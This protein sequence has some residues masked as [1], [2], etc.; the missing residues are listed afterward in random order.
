MA[1][2]KDELSDERQQLEKIEARRTELVNAV[3]VKRA[4]LLTS[5]QAVEHAHSPAGIARMSD[6]EIENARKQLRRAQQE[7]TVAENAPQ[8]YDRGPAK[9]LAVRLR[10]LAGQ[11]SADLIGQHKALIG[12]QIELGRQFLE[13]QR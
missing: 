8:E 2:Q 9:D 6:S 1:K 11:E 10:N 12:Q 5:E 7:L 4:G 13:L 3:Y